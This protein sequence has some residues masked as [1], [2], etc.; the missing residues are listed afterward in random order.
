MLTSATTKFHGNLRCR[1]KSNDSLQIPNVEIRLLLAAMSVKE[2]LFLRSRAEAGMTGAP[3]SLRKTSLLFLSQKNR[4]C[5]LRVPLLAASSDGLV[6]FPT[7]VEPGTYMVG[8]TPW[9][10]CQ[11]SNGTSKSRVVCLS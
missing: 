7:F 5:E 4:Q 1:P 11:T 6:S 3:E 9:R 8:S 10:L 2:D